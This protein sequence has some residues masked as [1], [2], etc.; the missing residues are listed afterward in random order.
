MTCES[1]DAG[2][3]VLKC[4]AEGRPQTSI[5]WYKDGELIQVS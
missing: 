1:S 5:F 3:Y 4:L 2:M